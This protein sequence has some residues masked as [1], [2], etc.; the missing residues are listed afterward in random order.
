MCGTVLYYTRPVNLLE[1]TIDNRDGLLTILEDRLV[2]PNA[3]WAKLTECGLAGGLV[4]SEWRG[5]RYS[6]LPSQR[7]VKAQQC[8]VPRTTTTGTRSPSPWVP[9]V[10]ILPT[11]QVLH[12]SRS[13]L[14]I[15]HLPLFTPYKYPYPSDMKTSSS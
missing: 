12:C 15:Q 4:V 1:H 5:E 13:L 11:P 6:R 3:K 14:H 2:Q 7:G 9:Q 10:S 8:P